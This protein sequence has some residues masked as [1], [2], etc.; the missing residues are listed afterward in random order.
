MA[1]VKWDTHI[2]TMATYLHDFITL[3]KQASLKPNISTNQTNFVSKELRSTIRTCFRIQNK[4]LLDKL[5]Y[6][7]KIIR[8]KEA[9]V[10][11]F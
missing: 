10:S 8:N 9:F 4:F 2:F 5:K 1:S 6:S 3:N 7:E 11:V